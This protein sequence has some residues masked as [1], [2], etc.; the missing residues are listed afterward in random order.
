MTKEFKLDDGG[1]LIVTVDES[2]DVFIPLDGERKNIGTFKSVV[3]QTIEKQHIELLKNF[4]EA[5]KTAGE[6]KLID[7]NKRLEPIKDLQDIDEK[8]VVAC[9]KAIDKGNKPFKISMETL[10]KRIQDL[11]LK[12]A[13]I[14]Q[15]DYITTQAKEVNSDLENLIKILK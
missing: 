5:E 12:K 4:M 1:N 9:K 11:D 8:I 14:T 13:L 6:K 7:F 3:T 15:I 10:S 2:N